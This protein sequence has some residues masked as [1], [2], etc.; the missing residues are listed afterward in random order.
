MPWL[1]SAP[2]GR[3][4]AAQCGWKSAKSRGFLGSTYMTKP[5]AKPASMFEPVRRAIF[6]GLAVILP[7]LLTIVVFIWAGGLINTYILVPCE[8][9]VGSAIV[10][11]IRDVKSGIPDGATV[12]RAV[13]GG[14]V[15]S[16]E[17][18]GREY[19]QAVRGGKWI[20]RTVHDTVES[21]LRREDQLPQTAD[22]YFDHY[23]H[24]RYL[25]PT[26]TVPIF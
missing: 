9:V 17:F 5:A 22:A 24:M 6:R 25:R 1:A 7:P 19:V 16:F 15:T 14:P 26:Q 21:N 23:V 10:W 2:A 12:V 20:P 3:G 13:P 11:S 18:N 4:R 8:E